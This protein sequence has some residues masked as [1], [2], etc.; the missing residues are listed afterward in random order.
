MDTLIDDTSPR[1][2]WFPA[3]ALVGMMTLGTAVLW[4]IPGK[5]VPVGFH[6]DPKTAWTISM[7]FG[8]DETGFS[9][10]KSQAVCESVVNSKWPYVAGVTVNGVAL[11]RPPSLSEIHAACALDTKREVGL[12]YP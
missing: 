9:D 3:L 10:E 8:K 5:F 7:N 12:T 1:E 11:P 2:S 4:S 6:V